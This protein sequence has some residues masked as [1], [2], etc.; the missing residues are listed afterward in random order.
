M[1]V[2]AFGKEFVPTIC[3]FRIERWWR[4]EHG[5]AASSD[6]L[7]LQAVWITYI[8]LL[9]SQLGKTRKGNQNR[10]LLL[11]TISWCLIAGTVL[12]QYWLTLIDLIIEFCCQDTYLAFS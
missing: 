11:F 7:M 8:A 2:K 4:S 6:I 12:I 1:G 3:L 5:P 9:L 10:F